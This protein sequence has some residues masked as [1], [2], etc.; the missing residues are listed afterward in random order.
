VAALCNSGMASL[1]FPLSMSVHALRAAQWILPR[2]NRLREYRDNQL[3]MARELATVWRSGISRR[4][5]PKRAEKGINL[6]LPCRA[7]LPARERVAIE[8]V[9][10]AVLHDGHEPL[11][12]LQNRHVSQRVAIDK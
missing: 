3:D 2:R 1:N 5:F 4:R 11:L 9:E 12:P 7:A 6:R 8:L 10:V